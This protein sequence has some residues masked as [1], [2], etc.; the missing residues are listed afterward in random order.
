MNVN[1]AMPAMAP[2]NYTGNAAAN[3]IVNSNKSDFSGELNSFV[4][5]GNTRTAQTTAENGQTASEKAVMTADRKS[6]APDIQVSTEIEA[7][8]GELTQELSEK[9]AGYLQSEIMA[10]LE[11]HTSGDELQ[12]LLDFDV[13]MQ[14]EPIIVDTEIE[15]TDITVNAELNVQLP[16]MAADISSDAEV[17]EYAKSQNGKNSE[18]ENV[19]TSEHSTDKTNVEVKADNGNVGLLRQAEATDEKQ[20]AKAKSL[21]TSEFKENV[22]EEEHQIGDYQMMTD[23]KPAAKAFTAEI[24]SDSSIK[25]VTAEEPTTTETLHIYT[26][27]QKSDLSITERSEQVKESS[28]AD[29]AYKTDN[30]PIQVQLKENASSVENAEQSDELIGGFERHFAGKRI[31]S[32]TEEVQQLTQ[33]I[34]RS[35]SDS[36]AIEKVTVKSDADSFTNAENT[37]NAKSAQTEQTDEKSAL[38]KTE[39]EIADTENVFAQKN[40]VTVNEPKAETSDAPVRLTVNE[41]YSLINEK[42]HDTGKS[43]FTVVLNPEHLG[44]ITVRM[45]NESGKLSV[46]ILTETDAAKQLFEARANELAYNL[47]QND[48]EIQSYRVETENTEM[49]NESFDGSSKNPYKEQH[50]NEAPEDYDEFERLFDEIVNMQ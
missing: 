10:M 14:A 46:E 38:T 31:E 36:D 42:A 25:A 43:T 17:A 32:K 24:K 41:A 20:E 22:N 3:D 7:I 48:V 19:L 11:A 1:A 26:D 9:Y 13:Y 50:K 4:N 45:V 35:D 30:A 49:F 39:S 6:V 27:T 18:V 34:A 2:T 12:Q 16:D 5:A 37:A 40:D 21:H 29:M 8:N 28:I 33:N 23:D 15:V 44:K 47:R